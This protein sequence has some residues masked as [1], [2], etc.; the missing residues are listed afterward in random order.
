L[1]RQLAGGVLVGLTATVFAISF[2]SIIYAGELS[3]FLD[4][5]IGL[6][7]AGSTVMA[8]TG[9]IIFTFR[10]TI[11]HP[12]DVTTI[13]LSGGTAVIA[14]AA[15]APD[16]TLFATVAAFVALG[17]AL[18]GATCLLLGHLRLSFVARFLPYPVL[19]GFLAATGYLIVAGGIGVMIDASVTVWTLPVLVDPGALLKWLPWTLAGLLLFVLSRSLRSDFVVPAFFLAAAVLFY[20]VAAASG[21]SMADAMAQGWLLGPFTESGFTEGLDPG[22]VAKVDWTAILR[23]LPLL[24]G[25]VAMTVVGGLLNITAIN[26]LVGNEG[27]LDTD[28]RNV[29]YSN[30]LAA[31]VGGAPGYPA[32]GE[33]ILAHRM[34]MVGMVAGLSV[35]ALNFAALLFGASALGLLPKGLF[36]MLLVFIGADLLHT[37][38]WQERRRLPR[39]DY[40]II[41]LILG[42]AATIGFLEALAV[43]LLLSM[44][45]FVVSYAGLEFVRLQTTLANR[46][47]MVERADPERSYLGEVGGSVI[48]LELTGFLFFGTATRL[49]D[50]ILA[51]ISEPGQDPRAIILDFRRVSDIDASAVAGLTRSFT[52]LADRGI[53]VHVSGLSERAQ[54]RL[55]TV[56]PTQMTRHETLD[57]ALQALEGQLL[58]SFERE[59]RPGGT[60]TFLE[61]LQSAHPDIDLHQQFETIA[62]DGGEVLIEQGTRSD[63]IFILTDG[64]A[65]AMIAAPGGPRVMARFLPGA[66]VGEMAFYGGSARS[67][68]VVA[69]VP[70][71][72]LRIPADLLGPDSTLPQRLVSSIHRL[73]A[74]FLSQRLDRSNRLLRDADE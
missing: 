8:A 74:G 16:D 13:L 24:L 2:A 71:R 69:D 47:S 51:T 56:P 53:P 30:L 3:V 21:L 26:H 67:A 52:E 12:Q 66:L 70:L 14:A 73:A 43:G 40:A 42:T 38:L 11:M 17:S 31:G 39:L 46:R 59:R 45:L 10:G 64:S 1:I 36:A 15:L 7:L 9:A 19:G 23:Q 27:S 72:A 54:M 18:A 35:A 32:L 55:S 20:A 49:R 62:L 63:E 4:R 50:R 65:S 37:W 25:V 34:G 68:T 6:L 44:A 29:G 41:L 28:L 33:A 5:G 61:G 58:D 60:M 48:V 57:D 22:L